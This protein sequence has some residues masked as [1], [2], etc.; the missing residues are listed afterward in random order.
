ME[1]ILKQHLT[2]AYIHF[3]KKRNC[4]ISRLKKKN[5]QAVNE[6]L[7]RKQQFGK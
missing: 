5:Q 7:Q 4:F 1:D 2:V 3:N 6:Y